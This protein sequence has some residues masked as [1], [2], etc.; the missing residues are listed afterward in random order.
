MNFQDRI[1]EIQQSTRSLLCIGL[2]TDESKIPESLRSLDHP[3]VEFNKRIIDA[4]ADLVCAYKLNLAF[5]EVYGLKGWEALIETLAHIP[6]GLIRIADGKRNDIGNSADRYARALLEE[7]DFDAVT[8]NPYMGADTVEPFLKNPAKGAFVLALTSNPGSKDFQKLRVGS[9]YLYEKVVSKAK[10]WNTRRNVGLVVGATKPRELAG[11]R[12]TVPHMP[13]L[14]PGVGAQGGDLK[15]AIRNGCTANG[16]GLL[17]NVG[18]SILYAGGDAGDF[19]PAIRREAENVVTNI[20]R[21]R[22]LY[23]PASVT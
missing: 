13:I 19:S 3:L 7:M 2:D 6:S 10:A 5:Y 16:D 18:R 21:Y 20:Q 4:T 23:F 1:S 22:E 11:I 14:L 12:K 15:A 17:V 8:V 9:K